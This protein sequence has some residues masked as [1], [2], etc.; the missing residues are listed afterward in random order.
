VA[1]LGWRTPMHAAGFGPVASLEARLAAL[2]GI[3]R[4]P[5]W[6]Q[7]GTTA[8]IAAAVLCCS[9]RGEPEESAPTQA[10][11]T[12][13]EPDVA[14]AIPIRGLEHEPT[15]PALVTASA[16]LR[17]ELARADSSADASRIVE[18]AS[19]LHLPRVHAE[20]R[21]VLGQHLA[22]SGAHD[23]AE[24]HLGEA[25]WL[26]ASSGH[27]GI[28]AVA[29][30]KLVALLLATGDADSALAWHRHHVAARRRVAGDAPLPHE[31]RMLAA[32]IAHHE[33]RGEPQPELQARLARAREVCP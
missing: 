2:G 9:A 24:E 29:T 19:R 16:Q 10:E 13:A 25:A 26:S 6:L 14:C 21:L 3:P 15:D 1:A 30:S 18:Q 5:L 28:A 17:D 33:A 22:A 23:D 4:G 7:L 27:D 32:L 12:R 11:P 20:A 31:D 8:T